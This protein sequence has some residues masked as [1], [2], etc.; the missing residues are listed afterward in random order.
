MI[1]QYESVQDHRKL[2]DKNV[3]DFTGVRARDK[4]R[5]R[6]GWSCPECK[7]HGYFLGSPPKEKAM[8]LDA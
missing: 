7:A 6:L 1:A 2:D 5:E 8:V 4:N 3:P